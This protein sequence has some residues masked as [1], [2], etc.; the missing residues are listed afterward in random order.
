MFNLVDVLDEEVTASA[1]SS[2]HH[3]QKPDVQPEGRRQ[4][5]QRPE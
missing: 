5:R 3:L 2:D 4:V 1:A